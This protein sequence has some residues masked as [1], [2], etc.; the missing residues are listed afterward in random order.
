MPTAM[1]G[2]PSSSGGRSRR[3]RMSIAVTMRPR[4]LSI[5]AISGAA[6]GT[7]VSRSGT[8]TSCTR[9]IGSPNSCPPMVAVMYSMTSSA[10]IFSSCRAVEIGGLLFERRDQPLAIELG[11]VIV[12]TDL[13]PALDR[14][15]GDERRQADDRNIRGAWI[16]ADRSGHFEAV[17]AGHLE[18]GDD[19]VELP[20]LEE[21]QRVG[22]RADRGDGVA[23]G[24]EHRRKHV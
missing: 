20:G 23:R 12:E 6:S 5:P 3:R 24:L 17:H 21:H 11:H 7:R 4:R 10:L 14:I 16:A 22:A 1:R 2:W 19:D 13:A 15:R 8:N 9:E 18:V